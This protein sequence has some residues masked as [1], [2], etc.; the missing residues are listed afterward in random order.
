MWYVCDKNGERLRGGYRRKPDYMRCKMENVGKNKPNSSTS[1]E[2]DV[3]EVKEVVTPKP[4]NA[5]S[6]M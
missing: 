3:G 4:D 5:N 2:P 1:D 6:V